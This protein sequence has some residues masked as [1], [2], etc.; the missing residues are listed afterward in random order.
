MSGTPPGPA[1]S[2]GPAPIP[3]LLYHA[4][5]DDPPDW[6]AE[7]TVTPRDFAAHLDAVAASGRTPVR[8]SALTGRGTARQGGTPQPPLPARPVVLTFD[9]GFA[10]LPG[11]TA[12]ALAV[13]SLP[14][15]A[16]LTTGAITP[17][18]TS[19]LPPGPMM[20]LAQA[21]A[22]EGYGMEVGAHTVTH[23][24]L[25][26]LPPAALHRE[27][28]DAKAAL[29]DTL[30]HEVAH[31]AY[32]HGYSSRAVRRAA[33]RAGYVSAVAVRHAHSSQRD[34]P[35]RIAR[36]IVRRTH[37]AADVES[38]MAGG[39]AAGERARVAPFPESPLTLGWRLY[40]GARARVRGPEFAG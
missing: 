18:L 35:Y 21:P 33:A 11:P 37:T 19:L 1:P 3:V 39:P 6:I 36:L 23:A 7:F 14:A 34:E 13:R 25:D 20:T 4:V 30:G 10:D 2:P 26:T 31:L 17:G 29:E 27:L 12:E 5:M 24:Q 32:P 22:L 40:R 15:T 16:Y 9:D 38:W 8:I 28:R